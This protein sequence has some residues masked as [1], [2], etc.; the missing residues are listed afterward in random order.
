MKNFFLF[1]FNTSIWFILLI[2]ITV[3]AQV[4][5][6]GIGFKKSGFIQ[7]I[8]IPQNKITIN[9]ITDQGI[10][11]ELIAINEKNKDI[12]DI[13]KLEPGM[14]VII[15]GDFFETKGYSIANAIIIKKPKTQFKIENGRLDA[16]NGDYAVVDGNRIKLNPGKKIYGAKKTGYAGKTFSKFND[17]KLGDF[18]NAEGTYN[19]NGYVAISNITISPNLETKEDILAKAAG[20]KELYDILY[21]YW[22][23]SVKRKETF[24]IEIKNYGTIVK[25]K[26]LQEYVNNLGLSLVPAYAKEKIKYIFI[27]VENPE[28]NANVRANGLAFVYTGLLNLVQNEA[29]LA[30]ILGHEI[31]HAIYEHGAKKIEDVQKG[32]AKKNI[33]SK[34][35]DIANEGIRIIAPKINIPVAAGPITMEVPVTTD[36]ALT[37]LKQ[38]QSSIVDKKLS[39]YSVDEEEQADRV[40]L[41]LM[42]QAGYDPR[43]APEIWKYFYNA[44]TVPNNNSSE[45]RSSDNAGIKDISK[46][47]P[48]YQ[49]PTLIDVG[50]I[51]I[52]KQV[53]SKTQNLKEK[54]FKTH[55]DNVKRFEDLNHLIALYYADKDLLQK[56]I[57]GEQRYVDTWNKVIAEINAAKMAEKAKLEME[58]KKRIELDS[59]FEINLPKVKKRTSANTSSLLSYKTYNLKAGINLLDLTGKPKCNLTKVLPTFKIFS[60]FY[61]KTIKD[62]TQNFKTNKILSEDKDLQFAIY[63]LLSKN[64]NE[65]VT[66]VATRATICD[67]EFLNNL[68]Q[69]IRDNKISQYIT[70]TESNVADLVS[71]LVNK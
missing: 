11:S 15:E 55:P 42:V 40:G 17:L 51:F 48:G 32:E 56:S 37:L 70:P 27:V 54:S 65:F 24:G 39:D 46:Q 16:V 41:Y 5:D 68:D 26:V 59:L 6:I 34:I 25:S 18:I 19:D 71:I 44:Y 22:I 67:I 4:K 23:D 63:Y 36:T 38:L 8:N 7:E 45:K 69:A 60:D 13:N 9:F 33:F 53:R 49:K 52:K 50:N 10:T 30:A 2:S 14:E 1:V 35:G 57:S 3:Q 29:Q 12:T 47:F 31:T 61:I 62:F 21:P 28:E 43:E 64:Y 58:Y 20:D 66:D